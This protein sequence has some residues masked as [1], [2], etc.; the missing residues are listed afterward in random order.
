MVKVKC[1]K[2]G[3]EVYTCNFDGVTYGYYDKAKRDIKYKSVE[4]TVGCK[5][6][7]RSTHTCYSLH[8]IS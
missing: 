4:N 8:R 2:C 6:Y 5:M 3:K 1:P 7:T